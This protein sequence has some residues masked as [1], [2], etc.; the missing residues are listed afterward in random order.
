MPGEGGE[1]FTRGYIPQ[2]DGIVTPTGEGGTIRTE[3]NASDIFRVSGE[4]VAGV[5]GGGIPQP[6]GSVITPTGEGGTIRTERN[7]SDI[8]RV[9][10]EG[11]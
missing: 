11:F 3:R 7:A 2:P 9:S 4:G 8:F 6:D 1:C 5:A 10:G